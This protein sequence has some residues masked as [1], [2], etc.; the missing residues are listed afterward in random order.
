MF[1]IVCSIVQLYNFEYIWLHNRLSFVSI[2]SLE[3]LTS[4]VLIVCHHL[5]LI[6]IFYVHEWLEKLDFLWLKQLDNE[7]KIVYRQRTDFERRMLNV[8]PARVLN[9][10]LHSNATIT[11]MQ[12]YHV[13]YEH[14]ALLSVYI[15]VDQ[16]HFLVNFLQEIQLLVKTTDIFRN[17]VMKTSSSI[18]HVL[19]SV[20]IQTS[21]TDLFAL[22]ELL[23]QIDQRLKHD[24]HRQGHL[25]ACLHIARVNEIFVHFQKQPKVDLWSDDIAFIRH[26]MSSVPADH[27]LAT[28]SVY[29]LLNELYLFRTAGSIHTVNHQSNIFYLLGRFIGENIF[30]VRTNSNDNNRSLS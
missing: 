15:H 8:L 6:V 29:R 9:Y 23:F 18:K 12:H 2:E 19:F 21:R 25:S 4:V 28:K 20:D 27:C 26:V 17:I 13:R 10:Y 16:S 14:M 11:S 5:T 7:R 24:V 1:I 3:H 22:V 30:Q